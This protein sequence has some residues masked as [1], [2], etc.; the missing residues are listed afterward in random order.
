M[1]GFSCIWTILV[2]G[3]L[4]GCRISPEESSIHAD[5]AQ[6]GFA[7][8]TNPD[9]PLG[10]YHV[11]DLSLEQ[12]ASSDGDS[13]E[14]FAQRCILYHL[15]DTLP[16]VVQLSGYSARPMSTPHELSGSFNHLIIE[17]RFF[18]ESAPKRMDWDALSI[19]EAAS[20]HHNII[21][22]LRA[23]YQGPW[24]STGISKGGQAVLYHR[25]LYPEEVDASVVY[26]AP[27]N[28][29]FPEVRID[30]ILNDHRSTPCGQRITEGQIRLLAD[31]DGALASFRIEAED[32][33]LSFPEPDSIAFEL[34]VME[35]PFS[36]WQWDSDCSNIPDSSAS[37]ENWVSHLFDTG[38]PDFFSSKT[39]DELYPF[40][41]QSYA[42]LGMY[43]YPFEFFDTELRVL[44]EGYDLRS[45]FLQ[46]QHQ[47]I[48]LD[49]SLHHELVESLSKSSDR[50]ILVYGEQDP[51][52]ACLPSVDS[53]QSLLLIHEKG[54]HRTRLKDFSPS[55][56]KRVEDS[57]SQ[58][59]KVPFEL[60]VR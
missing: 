38:S 57:L 22:K 31:Y 42:Q 12:P 32:R 34:S 29:S 26:V 58:W 21:K 44:A 11:L 4:I 45:Y 50:L 10:A 1:T 51:W 52:T 25:H 14:S 60:H 6:A 41:Y 20:D 24:L 17:H 59:L 13:T 54:N 19:E 55:V 49:L 47:E 9:N 56:Q 23:I 35:Y 30:S 37:I 39:L 2:L 27:V 28:L 48:E 5:L 7:F 40:F 36:F 18:G 15:N 16:M 3:F 33:D 53:T 46:P 8:R 43:D